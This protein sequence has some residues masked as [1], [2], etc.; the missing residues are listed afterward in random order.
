MNFKEVLLVVNP[1][2]GQTNK[3]K[4]ISTVQKRLE[5][6]NINFH[7]F[8]TSGKNDKEKILSK[9][10]TKNIDRVIVAGGDGTINLVAEVIKKLELTLGIIAAGS[11]NGLAENLNLPEIL[12]EQLEVALGVNYI[13]LDILCLNG[14]IC[15]HISDLGINA[16]LI[17]NYENS[18]IRGKLG[19]LIQ[20]IPT[21]MQS[22][23][24]FNFQIEIQETR[25][26]AKAVLL[27]FANANK[28]GTGANVN[29][30]GK[31][32]D[33]VF[34]ILVF[35]KLDLID[36]LKTLRNETDLDSD[37]V[38]IIPTSEAKI[39]CIKPVSFQIDGEYIGKE[40]HIE[41][42]MLPEKLRVAIP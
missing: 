32:N 26:E 19:Y 37:F 29:P 33:G 6:E 3:T 5:D 2:S 42:K 23:Y 8:T 12:T 31:P 16:E 14:I 13:D 4:I 25:M 1:V 21:L 27:G 35:K 17:K 38:E 30:Q 39:T 34:E 20:S 7:L 18:S 24:P 15:L 22:E 36:I 10:K 40:T 28:Y 41:I 11:A 9:I